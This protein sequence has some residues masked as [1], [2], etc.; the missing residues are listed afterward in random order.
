MI[1]GEFVKQK[2]NCEWNFNLN[3]QALK[4]FSDGLK[5]QADFSSS[6]G[7]KEVNRKKNRYKDILPCKKKFLPYYPIYIYV[8][9]ALDLKQARSRIQTT[10]VLSKNL[11][12]FY[13]YR[14]AATA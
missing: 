14:D 9:C 6:E 4:A 2:W 11:Q 7:E 3:F 5:G 10:I 12:F 13:D 1:S 8:K